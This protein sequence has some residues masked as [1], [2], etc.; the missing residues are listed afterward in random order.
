[1]LRKNKVL[2]AALAVILLQSCTKNIDSINNETK[3]PISAPPG[4]LFANAVR[5][6]SDGLANAS[7][8][9]NVWRF[10]VKHWAMTTYQDEAR[11]NFTTR[12]IP[13]AWWN[14]MYKDV[15]SDMNDASR[16]VKE[17]ATITPAVKTNQLAILDVMQVY[18]YSILVNTF[19]DVPYSQALDFTNTRPKYDDAKT[20]YTDLMKRL[21]DD[22]SKMSTSAGAGFT[23][24][25]DLLCGASMAKWIKFANSLRFKMGMTIADVDN[26][27]AKAAVEA[28]DAAALTSAADNVSLTYLGSTPNTN[29]LYTD[30]VLGARGDYVAATDLM[31]PLLAMSDPRTAGFF[32]K[33]NDGNFAGGVVG[34]N[35][36]LSVTSQPSSKVSAATAPN[37]F[38]D[39]SE[40]EFFR[41]EAIERGYNVAG[42]AAAHYAN[43]VTASIVYW[44]GTTGDAATYL[45][46][47]DVAYAT[48]TGDWHQKIGFQKWIAMYNRPYDGWTELRRLDYPKL[49]APVSAVSG[50]P[51]RFSYPTAEQQVNADNWTSASKAIGGD[52]VETKLWWDK[53]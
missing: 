53:N 47:P 39:Y 22:I 51:N 13:Q 27:T 3:R 6:L 15:L 9:I 29:P 1:M 46:R 36:T 30:I 4:A 52:K 21:N 8:S 40:I 19:G 18:T 32:A 5:N 42:T 35:N 26:A 43:A 12:N 37:L 48:A 25:E 20:V 28:S 49:T 41:A 44:G 38:M 45:L 31:T 34:D 23:S 17:D 11:Y 14:R 16:L 2:I 7:V 10:T 50:F 33:N 24:T